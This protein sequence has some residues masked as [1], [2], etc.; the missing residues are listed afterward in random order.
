VVRAGRN[1]EEAGEWDKAIVCYQKGLEVDSLAE[2]LWRGL[3]S[4]NIRT[5]RAAEAHAAYRRCAR[6]FTA[7]LGV[8]PSSDL[9]AILTC[10][11][12]ATTP[13]RE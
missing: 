5:G 4:C 12:N 11:K 9:Q 7:V 3:I 13:A 2:D 6:T 10:A 8:N 1:R